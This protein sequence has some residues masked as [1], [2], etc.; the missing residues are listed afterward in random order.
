MKLFARQGSVYN[1]ASVKVYHGYGHTHNLVVYGHVFKSKAIIWHKFTNN[2]FYNA[3]RLFRLFLVNPFPRAKIR[4]RWQ[5]Q[6]LPGQT[7]DD[8][9]FKFEW[10]ATHEVEAGWHHLNVDLIDEAGNVVKTADGKMFVPHS[11]QFAFISD[12]DDT[13]M[14]SYSA[15]IGRRLKELFIRNPRTRSMF[16]GVPEHYKLLSLAHTTNDVPNAFFYV[17][18]SEW[19]LYDYLNEFF[20][21]NNLPRGAFLLNQVKRWFELWKTGKTKHMG[22]LLRVVRILEAFPSQQFILL[23]DNTQSDPSIYAS[24]AKKL[25]GKIF[26]IYIRNIVKKNEQPA[27]A[28]LA[29]I[30]ASGVHTCLFDHSADAIAHSRQIGLVT[31]AVKI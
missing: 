19:N 9:F 30:A 24:V 15:T 16:P 31:Q 22:K 18:S 2:I 27:K 12:I 21:F 20:K 29:E 13:I 6:V 14:I 1:H 5:D 3:L 11:T 23:G 10:K 7:E 26:A 25:P 8:G 17:S 4:L 28:I